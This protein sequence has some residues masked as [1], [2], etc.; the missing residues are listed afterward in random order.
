MTAKEPS[1]IAKGTVP[2]TGVVKGTVPMTTF[3]CYYRSSTCKIPVQ[4]E[5]DGRNNQ[6]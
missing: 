3:I 6:N 5:R 2:M 4:E 1:L